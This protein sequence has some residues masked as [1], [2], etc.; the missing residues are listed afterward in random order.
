MEVLNPNILYFAPCGLSEGVGGSAR[1]RNMLDVLEQLEANIQ[2][3]S[4]LPEEKSR[5]TYKRI[6][7]HLN[8]TT[9]SVRKASPKFFK[10][11]ALVLIFVH[12]LRYVKKSNIIFAHSPGIVSGFPAFILAKTFGKPL[13]VDHMDTKDPD[14]PKFIYNSVL[15]NSNS[16]FAI[17]RFLEEEA[18][19]IGGRNVVYLPVFVDTNAFQKDILERAKI[20]KRLG[21]N[22]KEIVIGYAGSFW[23]FE[24]LSF[25]LKVFK[26]LSNKYDY[27]RL[28]IVGEENVP[29]SDNVPQLVDELALEERVI[30]VPR[31]P[32]E[33]MPEYLSACDILCSPKIDCAENR[34]ANP[35][36]IYEYMSMGLPTVVSA[37]GEISNIIE[38]GYDG[39]LVKP[40]D[41]ND[42]ETSLEYVIQNLDS[43]KEAGERA[44][45]KIIKNYSQQ[46]LLKKIRQ[47]LEE[48]GSKTSWT[49]D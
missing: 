3:I 14:T 24:G 27:I 26:N 49:S 18:K 9:L 31:Q 5:V 20:R 21:I 46:V 15:K 39:F 7:N 11:F 2:L 13:L 40:G 37:V 10:A 29:G 38:D 42:L 6:S 25:L 4:Y 30:V 32:Y 17:S 12:G 8:T 41:E 35:I 43:A 28:V 22:D 44:R 45:E 48:L 33:S 34:A 19:E 23:H 47:A 16:V 36:K 1:L